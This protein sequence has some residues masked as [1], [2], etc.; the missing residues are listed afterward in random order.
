MLT[1]EALRKSSDLLYLIDDT[2]R[3]ESCRENLRAALALAR[4][5]IRTGLS[6]RE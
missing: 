2:W 1:L 3:I 4:Q 5:R 6:I